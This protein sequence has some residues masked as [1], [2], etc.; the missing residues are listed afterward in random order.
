MR[1]PAIPTP[2]RLEGERIYLRPLADTD[3]DLILRWRAD[4]AVA[5]QLFSE[6]S[7]TRVE[8]EVWLRS[9]RAAGNRLEFVIVGRN[10]DR[11][12]GTIGLAGITGTEAEYGVMIGERDWR[13]RG[14]AIDASEV[15]L[16]FAFDVLKLEHVV[17]R[18]FADNAEARRLYVRI[19]FV[20]DPSARGERTKDGIKR[21]TSVMRLR[22]SEWLERKTGRSRAG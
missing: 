3:T 22:R 13:G 6:R 10:G 19:G 8:H 11:P 1:P 7:P 14:I 17:L 16:D 4:T 18:M 9:L 21:R 15:L 2:E 20:E 12:I 5:H